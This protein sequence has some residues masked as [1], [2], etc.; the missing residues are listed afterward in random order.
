MFYK[1]K[2]VPAGGK[3]KQPTD[4]LHKKGQINSKKMSSREPGQAV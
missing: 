2:E 3:K 4:K 1:F